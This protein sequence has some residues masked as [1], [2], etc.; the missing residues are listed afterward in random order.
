MYKNTYDNKLRFFTQYFGQKVLKFRY[1]DGS[2]SK[3]CLLEQSTLD[4]YF[5]EE[6]YLELKDPKYVTNKEKPLLEISLES[7]SLGFYGR[8]LNSIPD[9]FLFWVPK[10]VDTL[11]AL[12]YAMPYMGLSVYDQ[13]AYGWIKL[14]L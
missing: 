10:Q 8:Q 12:G 1:S 14:K 11:R 6:G 9:Y 7:T 4:P 5:I 3:A 2:I 13:I